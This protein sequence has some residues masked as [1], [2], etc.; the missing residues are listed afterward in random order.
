MSNRLGLIPTSDLTEDQ[1]SLHDDFTQSIQAR[2]HSPS[3]SPRL[4]L[5]D[6][7]LIGPYGILLHHPEV[8]RPFQAIVKALQ[9]IPGLSLYGREVAIA[10]VGSRTQAAY[11]NYA[12]HIIATQR[13]G[14]TEAELQEIN[15]GRCPGT[16]TDEG[17]TVFELTTA[18]GKPGPLDETIYDKA[19]Q[20]L[21]KDGAA[22]VIHYTGFYSYVSVILNGFDAK[23]PEDARG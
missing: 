19:V 9:T 16:L 12:H 5:D 1:R 11:E 3:R 20:V 4:I 10:V 21:G 8:A 7:T 17:K 6:G 15:T 22:A 18:L 2:Y 14:I 23:V 13:A